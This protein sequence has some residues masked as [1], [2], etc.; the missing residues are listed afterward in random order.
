MKMERTY[1][2]TERHIKINSELDWKNSKNLNPFMNDGS[3]DVIVNIDIGIKE[4]KRNLRLM[5]RERWMEESFSV[6]DSRWTRR[7][8][9]K[10]AGEEKIRAVIKE[11]DDKTWQIEVAEEYVDNIRKGESFISLLPL[12][13]IINRF[14]GLLLH[15]ALIDWQG[16]GIA[17]SGPSG[18][19]KSTQAS[20]WERM[21]NA[22]IL[23][24]DRCG[25]RQV[26][27]VFRGYGLPFA[28]SS[29]IYLNEK[30]PLSA[31]VVLRQAPENRLIKLRPAEAF[32]WIY[33]ECYVIN[34]D[35]DYVERLSDAIQSLIL[36]VPV[37][38]FYCR[39]D[40]SAVEVLKSELLKSS[41]Q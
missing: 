38:M 13:R 29:G 34:W 9:Y 19:G 12:D 33:S 30:V 7:S 36:Q 4:E 15:S 23:N 16:R 41:S 40:N 3:P 14:N 24:G 26:D 10:D 6:D 25:I 18:I 32:T 2:I 39:P 1:L 20:L 5:G 27:G 28:G 21:E 37:Y 31:I 8:Y 17:F 11:V 22:R 35:R